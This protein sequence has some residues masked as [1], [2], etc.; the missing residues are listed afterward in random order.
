ML[1]GRD[2]QVLLDTGSETSIV[3]ASL[4]DPNKCT[5]QMVK[6][7]CVHGDVIAYPSAIVD[8]E[9]AGWERQNT[10][11]MIPEVPVDVVL[12]WSDHWTKSCHHQGPE[13]TTAKDGA[14]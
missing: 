10:V 5:Q 8:V 11:A 3:R 12:A 13:E 9:I 4:V 2:V 6:V 1:D 7:Q 14:G